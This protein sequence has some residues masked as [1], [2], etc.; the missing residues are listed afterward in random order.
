M[1][2]IRAFHRFKTY[3]L[4]LTVTSH[5]YDSSPAPSCVISRSTLRAH[6]V[7]IWHASMLA[8]T[9]DGSLRTGPLM[10]SR[11]RLWCAPEVSSSGHALALVMTM[12]WSRP[13]PGYRHGD[14]DGTLKTTEGVLRVKVLHVRGLE[15]PYRSELWR[16]LAKTSDR[17]KTFGTTRHRTSARRTSPPVLKTLRGQMMGTKPLLC[18]GLGAAVYRLCHFGI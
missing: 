6:G 16:H 10:A 5:T 15:A 13:T 11:L 9:L 7:L 12:T 8:W 3:L 4:I 14:E 2:V 1:W 17:L 18:V